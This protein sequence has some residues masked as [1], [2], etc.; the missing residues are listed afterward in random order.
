MEV[1]LSTFLVLAGVALLI[2]RALRV[3]R[4]PNGYPPG[5]PT[6]PILGNIHQVCLKVA[7]HMRHVDRNW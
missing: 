5:P 7:F 2:I 3:G 6:V 4:R 1:R